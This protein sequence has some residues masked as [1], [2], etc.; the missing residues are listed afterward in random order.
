MKQV[1]FRKNMCWSFIYRWINCD[2]LHTCGIFALD[3]FRVT[4]IF[5]LELQKL[6]WFGNLPAFLLKLCSME[7]SDLQ[8]LSSSE[9]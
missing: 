5:V 6:L 1:L 4:E 7:K 3:C 2:D 9:D 8:S